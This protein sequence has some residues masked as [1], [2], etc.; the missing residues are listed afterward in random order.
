MNK[1]RV[2]IMSANKAIARPI[3]IVLNQCFWV[4]MEEPN[5]LPKK[6]PI[7]IPKPRVGHR[8]KILAWLKLNKVYLVRITNKI[9]L[10]A[11]KNIAT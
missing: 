2:R 3:K 6:P 4:A 9:A 5:R 11:K 7:N 1:T 8:G 10:N